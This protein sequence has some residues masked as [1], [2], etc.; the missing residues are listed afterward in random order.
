MSY[1]QDT[2]GDTCRPL[3]EVLFLSNINQNQNM[4]AHLLKLSNFEFYG[5]LYSG[6]GGVA[7]D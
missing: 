3:G 7:C 5:N 6:S 2:C 4:W 1:A